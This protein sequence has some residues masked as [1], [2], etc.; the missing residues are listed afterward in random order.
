MKGGGLLVAAA[1]SGRSH[2]VPLNPLRGVLEILSCLAEA[3]LRCS[4]FVVD[5]QLSS[6]KNPPLDPKQELCHSKAPRKQ[7]PARRKPA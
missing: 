6:S 7:N 4:C 3:T 1:G 2:S 5:C